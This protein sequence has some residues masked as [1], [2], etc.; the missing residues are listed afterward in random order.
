MPPSK[1]EVIGAWCV[2]DTGLEVKPAKSEKTAIPMLQI[3][4]HPP[5][6]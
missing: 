1:V 3:G 2:A 5:F 4:L 6:C